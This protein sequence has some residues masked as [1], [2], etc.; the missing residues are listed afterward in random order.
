MPAVS[1]PFQFRFLTVVC[2]L[3]ST[4]SITHTLYRHHTQHTL[5][6]PC[7]WVTPVSNTC[8]VRADDRSQTRAVPSEEAVT[9]KRAQGSIA[10]ALMPAVWPAGSRDKRR[11]ADRL[12]RGT[13]SR[14]RA[15]ALHA[16]RATVHAPAGCALH[17]SKR[18][19]S[20]QAHLPARAGTAPAPSQT[21]ERCRRRS[22]SAQGCHLQGRRR[23]GQ[24]GACLRRCREQAPAAP[25]PV[26]ASNKRRC[27]GWVG[28]G[29]GGLGWGAGAG[30]R[31]KPHSVPA[32]SRVR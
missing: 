28:L 32:H 19:L 17:P 22:R 21:R 16:R 6:S 26:R 15:H 14:R 23:A 2:P 25:A 27:P 18:P 8:T 20:R 4:P 31:C 30:A 9:T 3:P 5:A 1:V 10:S 24:G 11:R 13:A 7:S 29:G 12:S